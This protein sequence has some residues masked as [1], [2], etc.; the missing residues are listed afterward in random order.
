MEMLLE[1]SQAQMNGQ[2]ER[3]S[4]RERGGNTSTFALPRTRTL[5][6]VKRGGPIV[7]ASHGC[8]T[9]PWS[10]AYTFILRS[11]SQLG[12]HRTPLIGEIK[13]PLAVS[14]RIS[15]GFAIAQSSASWAPIKCDHT[16]IHCIKGRIG[17]VETVNG[18]KI[19]WNRFL[20]TGFYT[21]RVHS[22]KSNHFVRKHL[23]ECWLTWGDV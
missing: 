1:P 21:F 20:I 11:V 14:I 8:W 10:R 16:S 3:H 6:L 7:H 23:Q 17:P 15:F 5:V 18:Q 13:M 9:K 19:C 4:R 12:C 22:V 2:C